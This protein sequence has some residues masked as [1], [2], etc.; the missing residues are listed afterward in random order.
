MKRSKILV[1]SVLVLIAASVIFALSM[2]PPTIGTVT[3]SHPSA[4]TSLLS[5]PV[6]NTTG[7]GWV[8][9]R[10]GSRVVT[11]GYQLCRANQ[12][13]SPTPTYLF[14]LPH[15]SLLVTASTTGLSDGITAST[16][17]RICW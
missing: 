7:P 3:V 1:L 14:P 17:K 9:V 11:N 8:T 12:R 4:T 6:Q 10:V 5:I 13:L 16:S 2:R 15:G